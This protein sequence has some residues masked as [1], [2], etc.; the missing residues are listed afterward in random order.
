M[1]FRSSVFPSIFSQKFA[2]TVFKEIPEY[3]RRHFQYV[4]QNSF[5][6]STQIFKSIK[7]QNYQSNTLQK[8]QVLFYFQLFSAF[9]PK[10]YETAFWY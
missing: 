6:S 8:F 2:W 9:S 10:E 4:L 5:F 7:L 1:R 3:F